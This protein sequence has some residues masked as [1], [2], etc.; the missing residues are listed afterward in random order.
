LW[1]TNTNNITA[2]SCHLFIRQVLRFSPPFGLLVGPPK[3]VA[4]EWQGEKVWLE[5]ELDRVDKLAG[6]NAEEIN[7]RHK[8]SLSECHR[9]WFLK[10]EDVL[11]K[12]ESGAVWLKDPYSKHCWRQLAISGRQSLRSP[13][14]ERLFFVELDLQRN[15]EIY[16]LPIIYTWPH[17]QL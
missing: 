14:S 5:K 16:G 9:R 10:F 6:E 13:F 15:P 4:E 12:E 7:K 17:R 2:V 3:A 1:H 8:E 11:H